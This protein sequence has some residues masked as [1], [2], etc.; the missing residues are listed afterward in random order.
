LFARRRDGGG[1]DK[2][3]VYYVHDA[4]DGGEL[5][6]RYP[7]AD[8]WLLGLRRRYE[9]CPDP[10]MPGVVRAG[11]Q[12]E[13]A[14]Q[15]ARAVVRRR[16]SQGAA[17]VRDL[18][19]FLRRYVVMS[20][21]QLIVVALW[22]VHTYC[23][24]AAE[25]TPY[26]AITSP[27]RQCGKTRL[28][29]VLEILCARAWRVEL[30]SEAV[31]YRHVHQ[32]VP[33]LLLDEIDAVFNPRSADRY[34]GHRG[35]L[36]AGNRRGSSVPRCIG[37]SNKIVNFKV[38]C[39][40]ALAAIGTLPDTVA[41]RA[42]PIRLARRSPDEHVE[43][44]FFRE[45]NAEATPLRERIEAWVGRDGRVERLRDARPEM[46]DELSDRM[47]D[48]CEP[49]V[50]IAE[51]CGCGKEA[52]AALID[53]LS[54]ERLDET[55]TMRIRL[56]RDLKTIFDANGKP[57]GLAT[58]EIIARLVTL[59]EAPWSTYYGRSIDARDLAALLRHYGISSTTI[60]PP[61]RKKADRAKKPY[62]GYKRDDLYD[63]WERYL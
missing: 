37:S 46:P 14:A 10:S 60:R 63:A 45:A 19:T 18:A 2:S 22:I 32:T 50:A 29:E 17:L 59:E 15:E 4:C 34:E 39:P 28:L 42:V 13:A 61:V 8:G 30:P 7:S 25:Q 33:T 47:Q 41:D 12:T 26:L 3:P 1:F 16:N 27:E 48:G 56:L 23:I 36:N 5:S 24:E 62:R 6:E 52:R 54:R 38:F 35:L 51:E 53:L 44:F 43:G 20:E 49:L 58:G 11:R 21:S 9:E 40:K 57:K 55:G 31:L